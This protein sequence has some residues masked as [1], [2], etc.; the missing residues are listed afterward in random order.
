MNREEAK[1]MTPII[2]AWGE[3]KT[4]QHRTSLS[5]PWIDTTYEIMSFSDPPDH[6]R[7]KPEHP[8]P[9]WRPATV[10][11]AIKALQGYT[12][13]CRAWDN[14][15]KFDGVLVGFI[16]GRRYSWF[17]NLSLDGTD[18]LTRFVHCEVMV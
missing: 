17:V 7:I 3:G 13:K 16:P 1:L 10:E 5:S 18:N 8:E 4:I 11:D 2:Q 15:K 9:T 6:Y 14:Q 12:I